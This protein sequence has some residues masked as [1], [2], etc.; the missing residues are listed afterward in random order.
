LFHN[1][2]DNR[3]E[4]GSA[5]DLSTHEPKDDDLPGATALSSVWYG[6]LWIIQS[7]AVQN[8]QRK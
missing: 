7:F 1:S 6:N 8:W 2:G 3:T 5:G 4:R